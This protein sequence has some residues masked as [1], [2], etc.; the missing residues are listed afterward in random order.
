[1]NIPYEQSYAHWV[2]SDVE[3]YFNKIGFKVKTLFNT[4]RKEK[5]HPFDTEYWI[6]MGDE[7]KRLGLQIK[8]PNIGKYLFWRLERAQHAK[9]RYFEWIL[10]AF[11]DFIEI[12]LSGVACHHVIFKPTNFEFKSTLR[13]G[14]IVRY[15]RWGTLAGRILGCRVGIK[16]TEKNLYQVF[17]VPYEWRTL[18]YD[19]NITK[20]QI[21]AIKP[22]EQ[23][24]YGE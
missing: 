20:E 21:L 16:V 18:I 5:I 19:I 14:N 22:Q 4:P 15:Y 8:K 6:K 10:Y 9:L 2:S 13:K 12:R 11:P 1:M 3:E 24:Y 23:E 17:E 7:V